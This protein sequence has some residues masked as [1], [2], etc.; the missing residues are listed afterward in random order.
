MDVVLQSVRRLRGS[1]DVDTVVGRGTTFTIALPLTLAILQVL[2]VRVGVHTYALPLHAVRE[3][4]VLAPDEVQSLHG[5]EVALLRGAALPVRR[6]GRLLGHESNAAAYAV[7]PS[8][9][10][11]LGRGNEILTVDDLVGKQQMV[12][13]PLSP[14]LGAVPGVEGA[15]VLPDGRVAPIL[16]V[17]GLS[18]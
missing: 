18:T 1:I 10:M 16:D 8:V 5:G 6:L 15:A 2:L 14:Y 3:T 17:E 13:K 11:S 9:V 4:L 7:L 12:V